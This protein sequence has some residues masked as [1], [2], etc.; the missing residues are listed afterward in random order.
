MDYMTE[1]QIDQIASETGKALRAEPKA[2]VTIRPEN[3]EAYWEGGING[4]FFRIRTDTPVQV[5]LSLARLIAQSRRVL[6]ESETATR[7]FCKG[8]GK[9][10]S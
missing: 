3:G 8:G 2:S 7:A 10:V 9:K 1:Q 5:P 6:V 4:H